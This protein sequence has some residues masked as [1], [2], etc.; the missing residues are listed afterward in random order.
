[1]RNHSGMLA[2]HGN[3]RWL[4]QPLVTRLRS[5]DRNQALEVKLQSSRPD[6]RLIRL[7]I[8]ICREHGVHPLP[9]CMAQG[10]HHCDLCHGF[11]Q[12]NDTTVNAR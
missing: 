4:R 1:M 9:P 10:H 3:V 12:H 7:F 11:R 5:R 6:Q 2:V 8:T